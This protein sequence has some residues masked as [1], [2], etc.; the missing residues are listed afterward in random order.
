MFKLQFDKKKCFLVLRI[1]I[2]ILTIFEN[3]KS[4]NKI[5]QAE[6]FV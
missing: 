1:W 5:A 6:L 2:F 3:L 4:F